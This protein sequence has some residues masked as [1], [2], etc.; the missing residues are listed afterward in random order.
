MASVAANNPGRRTRWRFA[1]AVLVIAF[2]LACFFSTPLA[3]YATHSYSAADLGQDYSLTQVERGHVPGNRLLSDPVTEM[4][5]WLLFNRD[6]LRA[7]R[8]PLWDDRNAAGQPHLANYQSSVFS[9]FSVPFYLLDLKAALLVSA[10]LKLGALGLFTFLFLDLLGLGSL[11]CMIIWA[12]PRAVAAPPMSFFIRAMPEAG[13]MS[14]P[15][16]SKHTPLPTSVTLG[17]RGGPQRMSIR[18]G[19]RGLA[20]PTWW[21]SGKPVSSALPRMTV[22]KKPRWIAFMRC[23]H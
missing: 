14:R 4:V 9:P 2:L 19:A 21:I 22:T 3:K 8:V 12:K 16:V 10:F 13:L 17:A 5:P 6:E 7:G 11:A 18:R 15:P 1:L 20:L 23:S